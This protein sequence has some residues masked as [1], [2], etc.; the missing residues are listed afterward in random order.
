MV[1]M[2]IET[3]I[4]RMV[5]K[6]TASCSL[7]KLTGLCMLFRQ[8]TITHSLRNITIYIFQYPFPF[9]IDVIST[10]Q[11]RNISLN[12]VQLTVSV[13]ICANTTHTLKKYTNFKTHKLIFD[14]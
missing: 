9:A 3:V 4:I 7:I 8:T 12:N 6:T 10:R 2:D 5:M 1:V 14:L 13:S 11:F